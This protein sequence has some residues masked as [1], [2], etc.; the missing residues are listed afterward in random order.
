[1]RSD[2]TRA[3]QAYAELRAYT[4]S[5]AAQKAAAGEKELVRRLVK[6]I[7]ADAES[8]PS[9]EP[10]T[11]KTALAEDAPTVDTDRMIPLTW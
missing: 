9:A 5:E 2:V 4:A 1:M 6:L 11:V 7:Q 3:F 8:R 10:L